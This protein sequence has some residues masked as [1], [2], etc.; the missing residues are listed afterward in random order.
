MPLFCILLT[1]ATLA[2]AAALVQATFRLRTLRAQLQSTIEAHQ[3]RETERDAQQICKDE[4]I[5][6][7][8]HELRTPLT[9]IRGALGLLA[10]GLMGP[11]DPRAQNLLR[12]ALSN[13]DRLLRLLN[14]LLDL[15]RL[16][17]APAPLQLRRCSVGD[18]AQQAIETMAPLAA[19]ARVRLALIPHAPPEAMFFDADPDRILQVL[20]NLLSNAIKFSPAGAA[21]EV[22]IDSEPDALALCVSD[23]GRGIPPEKLDAVFARFEQV[24]PT[25]AREKSGTGLGLAICRTIVEQHSGAIWAESHPHHPGAS[26]FFTLPRIGRRQD[27]KPTLQKVPNTA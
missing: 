8:S 16:A 4:F 7:V 13:A 20:T 22:H 12:I 2:L 10:T 3:T 24:D 19:T 15:E 26:F 6:N 17:S 5:A 25:D 9:S 1:V 14:D 11:I 27:P 18:L 23:R 21:V